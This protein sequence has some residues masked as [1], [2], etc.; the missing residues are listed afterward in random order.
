[1]TTKE[2]FDPLDTSTRSS[3]SA[4]LQSSFRPAP[5]E[6]VR[7]L[8]AFAGIRQPAHREAVVELAVKLARAA[9]Q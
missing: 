7:L 9:N 4:P 6:G 3:L 5:E 2:S 1:M 8:R